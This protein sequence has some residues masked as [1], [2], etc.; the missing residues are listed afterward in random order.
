ML[1]LSEKG[2]KYCKK[3]IQIIHC[4]VNRL[5]L[6]W[7]EIWNRAYQMKTLITNLMA[8]FADAYEVQYAKYTIQSD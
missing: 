2:S 7:S 6:R 4:Y 8:D 5:S 3:K 1:L